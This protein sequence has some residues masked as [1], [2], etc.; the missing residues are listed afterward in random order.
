MFCNT[1][2][3]NPANS[4]HTFT[5]RSKDNLTRHSKH[6]HYLFRVVTKF[7]QSMYDWLENKTDNITPF[8]KDQVLV[9]NENIPPKMSD[10]INV[11]IVLGKYH[12]HTCKLK[13]R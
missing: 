8:N 11:I 1:S 6:L 13:S 3:L 5:S 9:Y 10:L 7:W 12:T 4:K 2:S